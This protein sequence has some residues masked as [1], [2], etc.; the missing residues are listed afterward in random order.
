MADIYSTDEAL[1][2]DYQ[3]LSQE[4]KNKVGRYIKNILRLQRAESKLQ[5]KLN[6]F[7]GSLEMSEISKEVFFC[8][9]CGKS[10]DEVYKLIASESGNDTVFI[11]DE[12]S[13]LC[14]EILDEEESKDEK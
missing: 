13:R 7:T 12:C 1:L 6:L 9:F 2:S 3:K 14:V 4:Y 11:C 8:N 5:R 10:K